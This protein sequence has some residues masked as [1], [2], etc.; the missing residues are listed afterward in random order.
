MYWI[1]NE[2]LWARHLALIVHNT[3]LTYTLTLSVVLVGVVLGSILASS[4]VDRMQ[5]RALV[6]GFL[7]VISGLLVLGLMLMPESFWK[8]LRSLQRRG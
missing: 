4:W 1:P 2:I 7:Q 3:V 5:S 8:H 6:L